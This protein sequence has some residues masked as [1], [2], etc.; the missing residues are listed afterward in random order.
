MKKT[1][2][3]LAAVALLAS[4]NLAPEY[5]RPSAPVPA[6]FKED[7]G[8]TPE[9]GVHWEEARPHD[10]A[11]RTKWWRPYG[12][13]VL[14]GLEEQVLVSNQTLQADEAAY[15]EARALVVE[16]RSALFPTVSTTP[17]VTAS[18]PSQTIGG[19]GSGGGTSSGGSGKLYSLPVAASYEPDLWGQIHNTVAVNTANAQA[20]AGDLANARLSL[21]SQLA[22]DYF[23]VRALDE[24]RMI[25]DATAATYRQEMD[26]TLKLVVDGVDSYADLA[27]IRSQ[28]DT[29]TA[30]ATDLGTARAQFEHA[31]AVLAGKAPA[32]FSL[33]VVA[34]IAVP[35]PVPVA[36]P[37][38][39][40]ERRP[41]IAAAERRVAAANA[42]IGVA[43]AA[44]FPSLTLT[45]TGGF[46]SSRVSRLLSGPSLFWSLGSQLSETI[47][48][49]GYR[50]GENEQARAA[51][52]EAVATYRQTVLGGFQAVE[53]N[54]AALH[55]LT[56]ELAQ[57]KAAVDSSRQY[58]TLARARFQA[59]IDSYLNVSTAQTANLTNEENA[60]LTQLEL[61]QASVALVMA[62]GGGWEATD[63]P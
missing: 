62:T 11:V 57:R 20:S 35:P 13:P 27:Q 51:Y 14:D 9:A 41:D 38:Q 33:A 43:R 45:A 48:D 29:A 19:S 49:F 52:D 50:Q 63:L 46:E 58:L 21:Q 30:Q 18:R 36:L 32:D 12:D 3:C 37:S 39:L 42:Q 15:R 4:C 34:F 17:S 6:A 23:Q 28:L 5:S 61:M 54:L 2:P 10:D 40:L 60:V 55:I 53:D 25:L 59:G 44:Y 31:I 26:L 1:L 56:M 16:A 22:Q 7:A 47:L 24:E 8:S